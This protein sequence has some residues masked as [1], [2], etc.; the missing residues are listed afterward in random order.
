MTESTAPDSTSTPPLSSWQTLVGHDRLRGWFQTAIGQ[1]R[2]GGSFLL[3][4]SPG[5]GKLTVANLLART[6]LCDS[7]DPTQMAPCGTCESCI[8]VHAETH[9]DKCRPFGDE[10]RRP[11]GVGFPTPNDRS[12][13]L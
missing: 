7:V 8:Q 1:D 11:A 5:I 13:K 9:P 10:K 2:L 4:G 3:V 6:L 12:Q